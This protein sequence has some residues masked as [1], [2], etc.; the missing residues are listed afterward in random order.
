MLDFGG[1]ADHGICANPG[2]LTDISAASNDG[3]GPDI[4]G[5]DEVGT[6]LN[7]RRGVDDDAFASYEKTLSLIHI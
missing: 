6:G 1:V 7:H 2:I 4:T 3:S 5:A